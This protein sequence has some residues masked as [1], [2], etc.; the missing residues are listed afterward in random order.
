MKGKVIG[1]RKSKLLVPWKEALDARGAGDYTDAI[2]YKE[3][4]QE[5]MKQ[6]EHAL[7]PL[8]W[9]ADSAFLEAFICEASLQP[10]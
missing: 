5:E 7:D 3:E 10:L 4:P 6:L 9:R 2:H 1:L 8:L